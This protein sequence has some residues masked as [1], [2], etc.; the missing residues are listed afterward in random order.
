[1]QLGRVI[2]QMVHKLSTALYA[3]L[4]LLGLPRLPADADEDQGR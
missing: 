2:R 1:M 4:E 3:A